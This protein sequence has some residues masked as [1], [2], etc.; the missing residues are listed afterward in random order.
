[1][2]ISLERDRTCGQANGLV[3]T[4]RNTHSS[5]TIR[6][7]NRETG[8]P[9]EQ[10]KYQ[11]PSLPISCLALHPIR[12]IVASSSDDQ[13]WRLWGM[14][15]G[16]MI[17]TGVG[18]SDWLSGC[19]FHPNGGSLATTSGDTTVRIWDFS[20]GRCILTLNDHTHATW[21]CSFH[22]CGDFVASCS[23]DTTKVW[24]LQRERCRSTLLGHVDSVNSVTFLPF[25]NTL[26]TC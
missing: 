23:M 24:D 13:L 16:E 17:M 19:S 14:P 2:L 1:M 26:R 3:T 25:S 15:V 18:H 9:P 4:L 7:A 20:Q 5:S 8:L 22:S 12:F 11:S 6:S 10:E 21:G